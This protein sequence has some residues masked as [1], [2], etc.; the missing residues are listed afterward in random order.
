MMAMSRY[1]RLLFPVECFVFSMIYFFGSHGLQEV[2]RRKQEVETLRVSVEKIAA[3]VII[4]TQDLDKWHN[5]PYYKEKIAREQ[6]QMA[7]K[8]ELIYFI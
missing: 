1:V 6:L 7:R 5:K 8:D 4:L 2:V 3:D